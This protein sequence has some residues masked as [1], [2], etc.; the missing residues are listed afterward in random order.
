[1]T[2]DPELRRLQPELLDRLD[3]VDFAEWPP[4]LLRATIGV[5]DLH[6][7]AHPPAPAPA[8]RPRLR[9]VR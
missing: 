5:F 2:A 3:A 6:L 1:M 9:V 8:G 4:S 7:E